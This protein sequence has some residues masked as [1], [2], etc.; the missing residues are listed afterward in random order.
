MTSLDPADPRPPYRQVADALRAAI[1]TRKLKPGDKLPSQ[2]EL[3]DRYK[4]ARMTIQQALRE[5]RSEGLTVSRQGSGVYVRERVERPVGLRPHVEAAFQRQHVALDFAGFSGE[6]LHGA[7]Q[8]PLDKIRAGAIKPETISIRIL[9]PNLA[10]PAALPSRAGDNPGDDP[11]VRKRSEDTARRHVGAIIASV[12]ELNDLGLVDKAT[13]EARVFAG[14]PQFK[15]YL[16]NSEELF[17]A[18]YPVVEHTVRVAGTPTPIFDS[19]GKDAV[20]FHHAVTDDEA[21]A[22]PQY[23][24][25]A[26]IWFDS[27]WNSVAREWTP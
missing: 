5:L 1:L 15:L 21:T 14:T 4:V 3:A 2:A 13:A 20:L 16:L 18:F 10:I 17:F 26:R 27:V 7:I 12:L 24:E 6:T 9:L 23:V 11:D 8:E 19:L 25:Q 22:G